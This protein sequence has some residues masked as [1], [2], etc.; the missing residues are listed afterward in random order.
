MYLRNLK[1]VELFLIPE[2]INGAKKLGWPPVVGLPP[3][4]KNPI[5]YHTDYL[6]L[7]M[8]TRFPAI[9]GCSFKWRLRSSNPGEGE[10]V[11][12]WEGMVPFERPLVSYYRPSTG[13]LIIPP[14]SIST[15]LLEI[16]DCSFEW[17][18]RT[19]NIWE[20][21]LV[22]GRDNTVR[23]SDGEFL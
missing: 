5:S 12:I 3:P 4:K 8:C 14:G 23:K 7:S 16:L 11:G 22:G 21:E 20:G 9:F 1:S 17:G 19:P 2:L 13:L 6:S 10:D 18:L 15:R